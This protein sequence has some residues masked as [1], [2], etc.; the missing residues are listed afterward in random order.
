[1]RKRI[2]TKSGLVAS[3]D[4]TRVKSHRA[5]LEENHKAFIAVN[6]T[7]EEG[8]YEPKP[9]ELVN[10]M[11]FGT[12]KKIPYSAVKSAGFTNWW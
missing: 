7:S 2:F 10:C 3:S 9:Y 1:M 4:F 11:V 8:K 12:V 6:M 5:S